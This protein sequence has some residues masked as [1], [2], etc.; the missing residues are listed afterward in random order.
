MWDTLQVKNTGLNCAT[1]G[2][3]KRSG[4]LLKILL[5][6]PTYDG[7]VNW[8]TAANALG[9]QAGAGVQVAVMQMASSF[10]TLNF[11]A[12]WCAMLNDKTFT[13]FAMCHAD[14][15]PAKSNWLK[16]MLDIQAQTGVDVLSAV[17]PIKSEQGLTSIAATRN[18]EGDAYE[19]PK[20]LTMHEIYRLPET[21][22][23]RDV[24]NL[25]YWNED[26]TTLLV[27]TGLLLVDVRKRD[28]A[29]RITFTVNNWI[30]RK[31]SGEFYAESEP[32]D[33]NFSRQANSMGWRVSA[34]RAVQLAHIGNARYGNDKAW[35]LL[36][37]DGK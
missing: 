7:T 19:T 8:R 34:T 1:N 25:W 29:E 21:F 37:K 30:A 14:I 6:V 17:S 32:E 10:L 20:R 15:E 5:A 11:N 3:R 35:G 12:M 18:V 16:Q 9:V 26:A 22:N 23:G 36:D 33:W 27:N 13:H 2:K 28:I 24:A 4:E 31:P